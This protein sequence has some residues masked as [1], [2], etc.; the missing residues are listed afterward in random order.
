MFL[1]E[2]AEDYTFED[3]QFVYE[4]DKYFVYCQGRYK[5]T[6]KDKENFHKILNTTHTYKKYSLDNVTLRKPGVLSRVELIDQED[7]LKSITDYELD[8]LAAFP[9]DMLYSSD[10]RRGVHLLISLLLENSYYLKLS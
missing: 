1:K 2:L 4:R 5:L 7:E 3:L 8:E 6:E 10:A 9:V